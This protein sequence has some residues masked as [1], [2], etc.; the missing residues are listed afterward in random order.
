MKPHVKE[1]L[2]RLTE[3]FQ[4]EMERLSKFKGGKPRN[5]EKRVSTRYFFLHM[6]VKN[7]ADGLFSVLETVD[8]EERVD[9]MK[10]LI[11][12]WDKKV[13]AA[14][15]GDLDPVSKSLLSSILIL[16]GY[17]WNIA[18]NVGLITPGVKDIV[19]RAEKAID[20]IISLSP[21]AK[22]AIEQQ[23]LKMP[24]PFNIDIIKRFAHKPLITVGIQQIRPIE[25]SLVAEP[26]TVKPKELESEEL[27]QKLVASANDF[28]ANY[29][30][31]S[32]VFLEY[33]QEVLK[34][35]EEL[36]VQKNLSK[37]FMSVDFNKEI[38]TIYSINKQIL[39]DMEESLADTNSKIPFERMEQYADKAEEIYKKIE[40]GREDFKKIFVAAKAKNSFTFTNK[41]S[42]L[43]QKLLNALVLLK[44]ALLRLIRCAQN[45]INYAFSCFSEPELTTKP[46]QHAIRSSE[47]L[48]NDN[49]NQPDESK[50]HNPRQ[51]L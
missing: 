16:A 36:N 6:N 3:V 45:C 9:I 43:R 42:S 33:I 37:D 22:K 13:K 19:L 7:I 38:D 15:I 47:K 23:K 32:K 12:S 4:L 31:A 39:I 51:D 34:A 29:E 18:S 35:L 46:I 25:L 17:P 8:P 49:K 14:K 40:M 10:E 21:E 5:S 11:L 50:P 28:D 26:K 48:D 27:A 1:I 30:I 41:L 20:I 24:R 44:A 2:V